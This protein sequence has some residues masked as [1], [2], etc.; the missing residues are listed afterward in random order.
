M[1]VIEE[2]RGGRKAGCTHYLLLHVKRR[3]GI[4]DNDRE[5]QTARQR[6]SVG[7]QSAAGQWVAQLLPRQ[8]RATEQCRVR[9]SGKTSVQLITASQ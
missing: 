3:G 7:G 5:K 8:E 9:P 2:G 1:I 6:E 4:R